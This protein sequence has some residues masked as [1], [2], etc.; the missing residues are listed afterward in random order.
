MKN[1]TKYAIFRP[2]Y[3]NNGGTNPH[4]ILTRRQEYLGVAVAR[5]HG[6]VRRAHAQIVAISTKFLV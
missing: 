3:R 6:A 2:S 4:Q 1:D 5:P